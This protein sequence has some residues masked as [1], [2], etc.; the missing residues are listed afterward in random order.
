MPSKP[1]KQDKT[2][3]APV[4][5]RLAKYRAYINE[6]KMVGRQWVSSIDLATDLRLTTATVRRDIFHLDFSGHTKRGYNTKKL[7][8]VISHTL[9]LNKQ[10]NVIIV[11]AGNFGRALAMHGDFTRMGFKIC[12]IFDAN[13]AKK[14]KKIKGMVIRG[15]S[16]LSS[17]IKKYRVGIGII[18]VPA[19]AA[20]HVAN[21]LIQAGI[22]GL[23]NLACVD[24]AVPDYI[25][26]VETRIAAGLSELCC[27]LHNERTKIMGTPA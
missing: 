21:Q 25:N 2:L 17:V 22:K 27:C 15:M 24:L 11:G 16:S 19:S 6:A 23:L 9:G 18:A 4:I 12:G 13:P 3:P 10:C 20:Q 8:R 26:V 1:T 14:G 5:R 7:E